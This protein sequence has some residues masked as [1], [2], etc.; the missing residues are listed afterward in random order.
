MDACRKMC[1]MRPPSEASLLLH[2]AFSNDD[3]AHDVIV[4]NCLYAQDRAGRACIYDYR[5]RHAYLAPRRATSPPRCFGVT[6]LKERHALAHIE[7]AISAIDRQYAILR[8]GND[9]ELLHF[10]D[11]VG[12]LLHD[13]PDSRMHILLVGIQHFSAIGF[14]PLTIRKRLRDRRL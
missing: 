13:L 6:K 3:I 11:A 5:L 7:H 4:K 8:A 14:F 10:L 9:N 2:T 12:E 1:W